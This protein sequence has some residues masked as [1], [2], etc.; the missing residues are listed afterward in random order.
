[1]KIVKKNQCLHLKIP[2][3]LVKN[4]L[5]RLKSI[6]LI[7]TSKVQIHVK[8]YLPIKNLMQALVIFVKSK[9]LYFFL[10]IYI[11]KKK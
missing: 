6:K 5:V 4:P 10:N 11:Y 3:I 9:F 2:K 1:M 7:K 8:V